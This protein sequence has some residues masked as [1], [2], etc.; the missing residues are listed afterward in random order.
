MSLHYISIAVRQCRQNP[1]GLEDHRE[2]KH[3]LQ[4]SDKKNNCVIVTSET[5]LGQ[6]LLILGNIYTRGYGDCCLETV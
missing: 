1:K 6:V 2:K 5:L 3:H 4:D